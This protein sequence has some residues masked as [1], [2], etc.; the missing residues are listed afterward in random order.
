MF[1]TSTFDDSRIAP[2]AYY[3][4]YAFK[5]LGLTNAELF[6]TARGA[7]LY[8]GIRFSAEWVV[9]RLTGAP[10]IVENL[11]VRHRTID[12]LLEHSKADRVVELGAGL[13]RR[14]ITFAEKY[15]IPYIEFDLPDMVAAKRAMLKRAPR[16]R[17][18]RSTHEGLELRTA[19][20]LAPDF[21]DHLRAA[22]ANASRPVVIAEGLLIYFQ[23]RD[24]QRLATTVASVLRTLGG[25]RW[26]CELRVTERIAG[27]SAGLGVLKWGTHLVTRGRGMGPPLEHDTDVEQL[28]LT[29]GFCCAHPVC[30]DEVPG[31][32]GRK[33][34]SSVWCAEVRG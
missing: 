10:L 9:A 29:A 13:S 22:L 19:D 27:G 14:G 26:F 34:L 23:P 25:G 5:R 1:E 6:A 28:F 15:R 30:P 21:S 20:V 17:F 2:T 33:T 24:R 12:Y 16:M 31:L 8:W 3:T 11:E 4:A 18:E 7:A 32:T